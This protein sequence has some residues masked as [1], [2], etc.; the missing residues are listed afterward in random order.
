MHQLFNLLNFNIY[1]NAI[2]KYTNPVVKKMLLQIEQK[3]FFK[4][5]DFYS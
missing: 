4:I 3:C 1:L 2:N 5:K